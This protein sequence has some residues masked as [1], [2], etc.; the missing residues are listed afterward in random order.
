MGIVGLK[1]TLLE[2][3][4]ECINFLKDSN[5]NIW[6]LAGDSRVTVINCAYNLNILQ[7]DNC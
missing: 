5:I 1:D 2:Y 7:N 3:A 4:H 6:M